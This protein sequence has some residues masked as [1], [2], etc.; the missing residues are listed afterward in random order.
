MKRLL[1][2]L[3]L[4]LSVNAWGQKGIGQTQTLQQAGVDKCVLRQGHEGKRVE[5]YQCLAVGDLAISKTAEGLRFR[6]QVKADAQTKL[7]L[8]GHAGFWPRQ[9]RVDGSQAV[10]RHENGVWFAIVEPGQHVMEGQWSGT[11]QRIGVGETYPRVLWQPDNR[12]LSYKQGYAWI[13]D[14]EEGPQAQ[15]QDQAPKIRVWRKLDDGQIPWLTT[16]VEIRLSGATQRLILGPILPEG[17]VA[18]DWSGDLP[19]VMTAE[20]KLVVVGGQGVYRL[21][22]TAACQACQ[23]GEDGAVIGLSL[24]KIPHPWP[25][26][27]TWS[28]V[29]LREFRS[30][31]VSGHG[32]DPAMAQ[33]PPHWQEYPAYR[34]SAQQG[35]SIEQRGRGIY[36]APELS[37]SR[38]SWWRPDG[39]IH[40]DVIE[41][42]APAG[43]RLAMSQPY[44]LGWIERNGTGQR[45]PIT[46]ENGSQGIAWPHGNNRFEA[47][48]RQYGKSDG[49]GWSVEMKQNMS[50]VYLP[51]GM[52]LLTAPGMKSV[53][54]LSVWTDRF[55]LLSW[56]GIAILAMLVRQASGWVCA[57]VAVVAAV[58]WIGSGGAL[59]ILWLVALVAA[60]TLLT[61][62]L[63][64]GR[65]SQLFAAGKMFL[66]V[67]LVIAWIPFAGQQMRLVLHPQLDSAP[68]KPWSK[69]SS[70]NSG[71]SIDLSGLGDP[72]D[73]SFSLIGRAS[74]F[75]A[76]T[77]NEEAASVHRQEKVQ[78]RAAVDAVSGVAMPA[79]APPQSELDGLGLANVG[80][81]LPIWHKNNL[82]KHYL[83]EQDGDIKQPVV[84]SV[85]VVAFLRFMGVLV[86]AWLVAKT[87]LMSWPQVMEIMTPKARLWAQRLALAIVLVPGMALAQETRVPMVGKTLEAPRCAPHCASLTDAHIQISSDVVVATYRLSV[88]HPS[89]WTLP[90]TN[91]AKLID[92]SVDGQN[93]WWIGSNEI[94]VGQGQA[95]VVARYEAEGD[96]IEVRMNPAPLNL[97]HEEQGWTAS[98]STDGTVYSAQKVE[99][100]QTQD[101][102]LTLPAAGP[103]P[104]MVHIRRQFMLKGTASVMYVIERM[105]GDEGTI[106]VRVQ[107]LDGESMQTQN[108]ENKDGFWVG[109]LPAG[110]S[111]VVWNSHIQV[112]GELEFDLIAMPAKRGRETWVVDHSPAWSIDF[113]GPDTQRV[114]E[115]MPLPGESFK[116]KATRLP[117]AEGNNQRVD[118]VY[119]RV[120][121]VDHTTP[122]HTITMALTLAQADVR[123]LTIPKQ[124]KVLSV[125]LDGRNVVVQPQDG[126]LEV[127]IP[128]GQHE[129]MVKLKMPHESRW[130]QKLPEVDLGGPATNI[131][132]SFPARADRWV[133][134]SW[135]QG[136]GPAVMYWSEL[137]VLLA[138]ALLLARLP[139]ALS[140]PS[141]V[142]LMLGLSTQSNVVFWMVLVVCWLGMIAYRERLDVQ[143]MTP[144]RFNLI[145]L[146]MVVLTGMVILTVGATI[147][148]GLLGSQPD[149]SIITPRNWAV[150]TWWVDY[151]EG[152]LDGPVLLTAPK[153]L[154]QVLLFAWTLW[155][156][157]WV[158][159]NL[160][161]ALVAWMKGGYWK[162]MSRPSTPPPLPQNKAE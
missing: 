17:F 131:Q 39:W 28:V 76:G 110:Q 37:L 67:L 47:Q 159:R 25:E 147:T 82:G 142:L 119:W 52:A 6:V 68:A 84:L 100:S 108:V 31:N 118:G 115:R 87:A 104:P 12:E 14:Q 128:G 89:S 138:V 160:K 96:N 127:S 65:L 74:L 33:V 30:I 38:T 154:Y 7:R 125:Q 22:I 44:E 19:M 106:E 143:G 132:I 24:P 136:W 124:A 88:E 107:A 11:A 157:H 121:H 75:G 120:E 98:I 71:G 5:D 111:S 64:H 109:E 153:W 90:A 149:M 41:G 43:L 134:G 55:T 129:L 70:V 137:L 80:H 92:V 83:L 162:K 102:G 23:V 4:G 1:W 148:V 135:G 158:W 114:A 10:L 117:M 63:P 112:K 60:M 3:A 85:G 122:E 146:I 97:T 58:G 103:I 62:A 21:S 101:A 86:L 156:A 99:K 32:I 18:T 141:S 59:L 151:N 53:G 79:M 139:I 48:S 51:P 50:H 93:S 8:P 78:A 95:R 26:Q 46:V 126:K 61:Q 57:V 54:E 94:R 155:F 9:I 20:N 145:Q 140:L 15:R 73:N 113:E 161:R 56:F 133:L 105:A 36:Q 116:L 144:A 66:A 72:T 69:V 49:H 81:A 42:V 34:V 27:E 2:T 123:V 13:S 150:M 91:G 40:Y 77:A 130:L 35:L 45:M 152:V 29:E 16:E